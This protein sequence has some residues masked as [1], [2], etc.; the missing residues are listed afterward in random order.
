MLSSDITLTPE[1]IQRFQSKIKG[2][3]AAYC[4]RSGSFCWEWT[5]GRTGNGYGGFNMRKKVIP[6]HRLAYF[7]RYGA[8][9]DGLHVCHRCDNPICINPGHL[10][11]G[12]SAENMR[13][14]CEK[15]RHDCGRGDRHGFRLHPER[16]SRGERHGSRTK[17][18]CTARGER[19]GSRTKPERVPRGERNGNA[20]LKDADI[21]EI[22][23]M[24]KGEMTQREIAEAFCVDKSTIS[25]ILSGKSRRQL[26]KC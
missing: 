16:V 10:W 26:L 4:Y 21:P 23:K 20:K 19:H 22:F 24:R 6:V 7:L 18:E 5:G 14:K 2:S 8:I 3:D 1:E 11:L 15:G 9:P 25:G 12:T 17:P 13:D